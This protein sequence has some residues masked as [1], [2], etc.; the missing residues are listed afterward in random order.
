MSS[1]IKLTLTCHKKYIYSS[2]DPTDPTLP[3]DPDNPASD[4]PNMNLSVAFD[5][6]ESILAEEDQ[7]A[8]PVPKVDGSVTL[9]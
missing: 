8:Q 5:Y 9:L 6:F 1:K 4:S 7:D 2:I 3:N